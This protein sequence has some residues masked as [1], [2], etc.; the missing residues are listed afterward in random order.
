MPG[1]LDKPLHVIAVISN[2]VRYKS[3]S[4]L[5]RRFAEEMHG[6][7]NVVLH[8]VEA[9][10]GDRLH[11]VTQQDHPNHIQLR[12]SHELWH[13]ENLINIGLSR[14]PRDWE[15]VA[16][17][18]ADVSFSRKDWARET[19]EALQ[20]YAVVQPWSHAI[21]LGPNH[22]TLGSARSFCSYYHSGATPGDPQKYGYW[23]TGYAWAARRPSIDQLGGLIDWAI[24]GSAD[25]YM[26]WSLIGQLDQ[27]LYNDVASVQ[28]KKKGFTQAYVDTLFRW[29]HRAKALK[30]NIGCVNGTLLHSFHGRKQQR[31][32]TTRESILIDNDYNPHTDI[33]KDWQGLYQFVL[34]EPRQVRMRDQLRHYFRSRNEDSIDT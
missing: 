7:P 30:K 34:E 5:Y 24:L 27:N 16:W 8:T 12:T 32:Y 11:D 33:Q 26:G 18:D 4:H 20:H 15:Y 25:F 14:L 1:Y 10:F 2:P 19:I 23:H 17:I 31:F 22:E 28:L 13:K 9:A 21:D 29:Q 6:N 3:R